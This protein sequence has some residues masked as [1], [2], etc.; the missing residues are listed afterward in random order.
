M[1]ERHAMHTHHGPT[2]LAVTGAQF[3]RQAQQVGALVLYHVPD[4]ATRLLG[5]WAK[6]Q[7]IGASRLR[8]EH[9]GKRFPVLLLEVWQRAQSEGYTSLWV[10]WSPPDLYTALSFEDYWNQLIT[11]LPLTVLCSYDYTAFASQLSQF[12][13][14]HAWHYR[15]GR[16]ISLS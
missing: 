14:Q 9:F 3:F 12:A 8:R 6:L 1:T 7:E 4:E 13:Q 11:M 5:Q 2:H 10:L 15:A 16:F